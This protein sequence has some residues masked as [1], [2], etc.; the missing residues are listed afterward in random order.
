MMGLTCSLLGHAFEADEIEREREQR[1]D[2]VV[3]VVRETETCGRCGE[4]RVVSETTEVTS[5][6]D[7]D[8]AAIDADA[9][10]HPGT[11]GGA[12]AS[13]ELGGMIDRADVDRRE[14][15]SDEPT[16]PR[17]D[18][19]ESY[20]PP[21]TPADEDAEI[22]GSEPDDDDREPGEWPGDGDVA[23]RPE[24]ADDTDGTGE[25]DAD[26]DTANGP[27]GAASGAA[28]TSGDPDAPGGSP[29]SGTP[30]DADDARYA[31]GD[32]G[33][34]APVVAT[35]LREGDSCPECNTGWLVVEHEERN[36]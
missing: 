15:R 28:E 36:P 17:V 30:D 29:L 25:I 20:E 34:T 12:G 10:G 21:E 8:E 5:V 2:E 16:H 9:G 13:G 7:S 35:S 19:Q 26:E 6:L 31:C 33:F 11:A 22:L 3:T 23:E 1:G 4:Q 24:N 18:P 14:G 27:E 32:C